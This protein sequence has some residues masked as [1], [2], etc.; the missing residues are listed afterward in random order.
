MAEIIQK[1]GRRIPRIDLTPMVD[2]GFLLITFFV[3]TAKLSEPLGLEVNMPA[4]GKGTVVAHH[5]AFTLLLGNHH[6]VVCLSGEKAMQEAWNEAEVT[7]FTPNGLRA[8]LIRHRNV[9]NAVIATGAKGTHTKDEP[10]VLI[11][12]GDPSQ[13]EDLINA[14]DELQINGIKQYALMDITPEEERIVQQKT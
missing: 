4:E 11:K 1:G 10:F 13:Y 3:F 12:A 14:L 5:T 6:K 7:D 2:L 9:M 8:A